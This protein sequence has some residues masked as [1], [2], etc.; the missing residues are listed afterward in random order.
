MIYPPVVSLKTR[1]LMATTAR[2]RGFRFEARCERLCSLGRR[3]NTNGSSNGSRKTDPS[4]AWCVDEPR[5][6][7]SRRDLV[8][9]QFCNVAGF[10]LQLPAFH[11]FDDLDEPLVSARLHPDLVALAHD[12][13]IQEFDL[14]APAFHHVLPHRRALLGRP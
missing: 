5:L 11:L 13:T 14:G 12:K 7:R 2:K 8:Q 6:S 1:L 10:G 9:P 4:A 3:K